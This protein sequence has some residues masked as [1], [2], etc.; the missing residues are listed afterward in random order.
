MDRDTL[1]FRCSMSLKRISSPTARGVTPREQV[2]EP[3][4]S[5]KTIFPA[6]AGTNHEAFPRLL[7]HGEVYTI[8]LLS[9]TAGA[10][11]PSECIFPVHS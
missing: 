7:L 3:Q 8:K 10:S 4:F 9:R 1:F 6:V 2:F 5:G 11:D